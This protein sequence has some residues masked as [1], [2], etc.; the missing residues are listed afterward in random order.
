MS[1]ITFKKNDKLFS[2]IRDLIIATKK[3]L[4]VTVN[5]GLTIINWRIGKRIQEEILKGER[6]NYGEEVIINLAR[7]LEQDFGRGFSA[8]NLR[9]MLR[10]SEVF[11]QEEI[12]YALSRQLSW[13]YPAKKQVK[14]L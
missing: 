6:A 13:T 9:H 11:E 8:K 10:F 1:N 12:V 14:Y 2:D 7:Q 5:A 4:V 3:E